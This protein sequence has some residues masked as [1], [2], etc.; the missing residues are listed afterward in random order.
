MPNAQNQQ[1]LNTDP[2]AS[3]HN[4]NTVKRPRRL[5]LIALTLAVVHA[6]GVARALQSAPVPAD[7]VSLLPALEFI[8]AALWALLFALVALRLWRRLPG[9][10]RLFGWAGIGWIVY[11][12]A[13]LAL[14][15][16]AD[17]DRQRL[18]FLI[19]AAIVACALTAWFTLRDRS[20]HT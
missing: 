5:L 11:S 1:E 2:S 14:F 18:P 3:S 7:Q 12:V 13:R 8:A 17:Y 9:A 20:R 15:A 4:P 16:R 10:R 6:V 19:L